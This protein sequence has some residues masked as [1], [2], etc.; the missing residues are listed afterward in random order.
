LKFW[1]NPDGLHI[2]ALQTFYRCTDGM[3]IL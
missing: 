1:G 2:L 3:S